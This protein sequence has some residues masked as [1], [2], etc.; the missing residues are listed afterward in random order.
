MWTQS[1]RLFECIGTDGRQ[2]VGET[3]EEELS[4]EEL[5]E[6]GLSEEGRGG[7]K[8]EQERKQGELLHTLGLAVTA[9]QRS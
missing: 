2:E 8:K 5:S 6:E 9:E 4:E 3:E 1:T 7:R